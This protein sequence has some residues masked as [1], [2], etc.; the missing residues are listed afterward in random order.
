M[1]MTSPAIRVGE[2]IR[3][4]DELN[5]SG[6]RFAH[7]K[8]N[9]RLKE[10]LE[11]KTD[12]DLLIHKDSKAAFENCMHKLGYKKLQSPAWSSYPHVEDWLAL[13]RESGNF[14]HL[15][16][17]YA[18]VTG[19]K[20]VKHLYLPWEEIFFSHLQTDPATGWPIPV[21]EM[22]AI[23]LF[24]RLSAKMPPSEREKKS[25]NIPPYL[26]E[27]LIGLL[28][29]S[30]LKYFIELCKELDLSV[31]Q[32]LLSGIHRIIEEEDTAEILR[33]SENFYGQV[34]PFYRK[35][36]LKSR[37]ASRYY[38]TYLKLARLAM[39]TLGPISIKKKIVGGGKIIALIGSDGSGKSTLS[40]DLIHWLSY[41]IDC[42]YFYLGKRPYIKS[43][44]KLLKSISDPFF[45]GDLKA[46]ISRKV[47]K[48]Y[49]FIMLIKKKLRMVK[50]A[51]KLKR[52]GSVVLCDRFPQV[53][54]HGISDG[55]NLQHRRGRAAKWEKNL[56][57]QTTLLEP[58]LV[59]KLK[60][61][62]EVAFQRKPEHSMDMI[63]HKCQIIEQIS[64]TRS[65]V[66]EI[67][68]NQPYPQVL[69][70]IKREI[71]NYL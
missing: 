25:K 19:I 66:V 59:F 55:M 38:R 24:I 48:N 49:Y 33:I 28:E 9:C 12:L 2:S 10:S 21:A 65:K 22:E 41:K 32:D 58:D 23:I 53:S 1:A 30:N 15:H 36:W 8:S 44:G 67:D 46:R 3:L 68:A 63:R 52:N 13:D 57:D 62:P 60:V 5:L 42:H 51:Q 56:F 7:W 6:V 71:W 27:E 54:V 17:H 40:N 69:L 4:F 34:R 64:F 45:S 18:L 26:I 70:N 47:V 29:N 31:P 14:L 37:L 16:T 35:S 20:H 43:H 50:L 61:S 39:T 11:G